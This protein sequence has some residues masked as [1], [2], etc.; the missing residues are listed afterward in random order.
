MFHYARPSGNPEFRASSS[1][2]LENYKLLKFHDTGELLLFD[3][4]EDPREQHELAGR[5]PAVVEELHMR[6][7]GYLDEVNATIPDP[8]ASAPAA[9]PGAS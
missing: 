3:I 7:T 9:L 8:S 5:M 1:I 6:L 2:Y 4:V